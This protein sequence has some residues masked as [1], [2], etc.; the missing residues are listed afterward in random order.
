MDQEYLWAGAALPRSPPM[1]T[2][3]PHMYPRG[4][5]VAP[6]MTRPLDPRTSSSNLPFPKTPNALLNFHPCPAPISISPDAPLANSDASLANSDGPLANFN[7][8]PAATDT[9]PGSPKP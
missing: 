8:F 5:S 9:Y 7:A 6:V 2:T 4:Y 1:A 3:P